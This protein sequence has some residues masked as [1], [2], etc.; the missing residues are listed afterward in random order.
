M[1][2]VHTSDW[3]A[4]RVFKRV[5]RLPE[6]ADVLEHLGDWLEHDRTDLLLVSGDI[7]DTGAPPPEAERLVFGFFKR[8][9]RAG[10]R[11]VVIGGNHDSPAR[12][13]AWISRPG[14]D[15]VGVLYVDV[16]LCPPPG[17][18]DQESSP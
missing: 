13:E 15:D 5:D 1:R 8:V 2:I 7:F 9:G 3:H 14:M 10:V 17:C 18:P 16:A 4:G 11:T 12:L 6:L